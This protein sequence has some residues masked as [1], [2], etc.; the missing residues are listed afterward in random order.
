LTYLFNI[1]DLD[2]HPE[3]IFF[4]YQPSDLENIAENEVEKKDSRNPNFVRTATGAIRRVESTQ[5]LFW[6]GNHIGHSNG[7]H[8][9]DSF[10][11]TPGKQSIRG[12]L[13]RSLSAVATS[14]P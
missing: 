3:S 6:G 12:A 14:S 2:I 11:V 8:D 10:F 7:L 9:D 4:Q 1:L 13:A 5:E